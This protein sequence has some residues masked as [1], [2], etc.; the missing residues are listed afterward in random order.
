M[1]EST[2]LHNLSP[3][4]LYKKMRELISEEMEIRLKP[5]PP[6]DLLTKKEV[7]AK[8]RLS[9]PT[10]QRLMSDG[11]LPGLRIGRRI[12]FKSNQVDEALKII[13]T[14]KYKKG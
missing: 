5:E 12:L 3:E 14:L 8:L 9:L 11:T 2:I 4:D 10:V 1:Q 13:H 6:T 7:A